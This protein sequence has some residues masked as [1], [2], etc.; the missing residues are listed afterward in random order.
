MND[1]PHTPAKNFAEIIRRMENAENYLIFSV[2]DSI[3]E[4]ARATCA[5]TT[6]TAVFARGLADRFPE[7]TVL[8]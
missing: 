1:H 8:R 3:T 7:K 2:G 6:Y 5:E 4:G